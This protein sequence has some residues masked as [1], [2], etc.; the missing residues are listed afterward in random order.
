MLLLFFQVANGGRTT[1]NI[2][3]TNIGVALGVNIGMQS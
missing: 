3:N 2:A 1:K